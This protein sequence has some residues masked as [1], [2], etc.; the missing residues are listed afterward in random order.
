VND[1]L[2]VARDAVRTALGDDVA[3]ALE[4]AAAAV[5]HRETLLSAARWAATEGGHCPDCGS[6]YVHDTKCPTAA[7]LHAL[8]PEWSRA[9]V[10]AAH[11]SALAAMQYR[12]GLMLADLRRFDS[13]DAAA[14]AMENI[15]AAQAAA[16]RA[17]RLRSAA[18]LLATGD[19]N[20][21][22]YS[23]PFLGVPVRPTDVMMSAVL[24]A[25]PVVHQMALSRDADGG[26]EGVA[27]CGAANPVWPDHLAQVTC[28]TC[29]ALMRPP[30]ADVGTTR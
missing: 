11:E 8:D 7:M 25:S 26:P 9:E 19:P 27:R 28:P 20:R 16:R 30:V 23:A 12:R 10:N 21:L 13:A 3:D 24:E 4:W 18:E 22:T 29:L 1:L 15:T 6:A 2:E 14:Y 17:E 5:K